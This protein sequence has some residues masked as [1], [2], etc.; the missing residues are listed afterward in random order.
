MKKFSEEEIKQI[1]SLYKSGLNCSQVGRKINRPIS[2]VI[3]I[4]KR[5]KIIIRHGCHGKIKRE[6]VEEIIKLYNNGLN[7]TEIGKKYKITGAAVLSFI[8]RRNI[9]TRPWQ[10]HK[11]HSFNQEKFQEINSA[12]K[13]YWLGFLIGDGSISQRSDSLRLELSKIDED[14]L[15]KFLKFMEGTQSV[16]NSKKNCSYIIF[17][18]KNF[19]KS[20]SRYGLVKNKTYSTKTPNISNKYLHDFYRGILDSDG[21][22]IRH[23]LVNRPPQHEFGFSS[24]S[25]QL[26]C[27]LQAWLEKNLGKPCGKV[28]HRQRKNQSV[29]QFV[30]GGN[31][32][33]IKIAH[34]LYNNPE[35]YLERKH[36]SLLEYI[37]EINLH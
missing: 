7:G 21:W 27:E 3:S 31:K 28:I 33:F 22:I 14:H 15:Y 16:T 24:G 6:N 34:L 35:I 37:K 2:S 36:K 5:N 11:K 8:K 4:L 30:V 29:Y 12:E 23:K 18:G 1:V 19:V 26:L 17:C 20:L 32:N 9:K 13:A 10:R 25:K